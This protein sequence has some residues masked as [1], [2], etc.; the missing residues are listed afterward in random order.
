MFALTVA[1]DA[2][3]AIRRVATVLRDGRFHVSTLATRHLRARES[4]AL[5]VVDPSGDRRRTTRA[6]LDARSDDE[7]RYLPL[8]VVA[9][10]DHESPS[11]FG[12]RALVRYDGPPHAIVAEVRRMLLR[13]QEATV[14]VHHLSGAIGDLAIGDVLEI[15]ARTSRDAVIRVS[16]GAS[17]GVL[18]VRGG[19]VVRAEWDAW[20]GREALAALLALREGRFAAELRTADDTDQ[21]GALDVETARAV[22]EA[23][24]GLRAPAKRSPPSG[25][26]DGRAPLAALASAT[27]NAVVAYARQWL[28]AGVVARAV[29]DARDAAIARAPALAGFRVTDAAMVTVSR[30]DV[31]ATIDGA[32]LG[33]W[34]CAALERLERVRPGRFGRAELASIVGGL[35]RMHAQ[36]GWTE[37]FTTAA[38]AGAPS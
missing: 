20:T 32:G 7:L 10:V 12:A 27:I 19:R 33:R 26:D 15:F 31:A 8:C 28:P 14:L 6:V 25:P 5:V 29:D 35:A 34:V 11:T 16:K 18:V 2:E 24:D 17:R 36:V 21:V 4:D 3:D 13:L 9:N 30:L 22:L 37:A 38:H 23:Q 1:G